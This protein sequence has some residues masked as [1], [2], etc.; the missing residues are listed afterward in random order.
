ML[1]DVGDEW[2]GGKWLGCVVSVM[3]GVCDGGDM[4]VFFM[5]VIP[6]V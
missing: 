4:L 1:H 6:V 5:V 3:C 2:L